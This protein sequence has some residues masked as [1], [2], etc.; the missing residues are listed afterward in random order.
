VEP[1]VP[2][3]VEPV[4]PKVAPVQR[5]HSSKHHSAKSSHREHKHG[6]AAR[7]G[8]QPEAARTNDPLGG[9]NL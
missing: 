8:D 9:L 4:V 5:H 6:A 2:K 1:I 7:S 3:V